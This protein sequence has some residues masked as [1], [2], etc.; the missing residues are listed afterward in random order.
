VTGVNTAPKIPVYLVPEDDHIT[1]R[2]AVIGNGLAGDCVRTIRPGEKLAGYSYEA[3]RALGYRTLY[4][5]N[6]HV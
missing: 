5:S 1:A 4:V 6:P 2:W 3:L